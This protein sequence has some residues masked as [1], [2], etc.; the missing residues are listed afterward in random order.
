MSAK[1]NA[2][3]KLGL[4]LTEQEQIMYDLLVKR[5]DK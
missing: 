5:G 4:Q 2:K 1:I 3:L